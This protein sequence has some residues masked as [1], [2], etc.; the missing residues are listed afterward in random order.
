VIWL[1]ARNVLLGGSIVAFALSGSFVSIVAAFV[2][3]YTLRELG[4]AV[5]GAWVNRSI[6]SGSRATVLSAI[7]QMDAVGQGCG[8]PAIG[9]VGA[10]L[11]LRAS[12]LMTTTLMAPVIGLLVRALRLVPRRSG[13]P[14]T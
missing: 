8:G 13:S 10:R 11:G 12:M 2:A 4:E 5:Q 7:S 3:V 1:I 6:D 9:A 14:S